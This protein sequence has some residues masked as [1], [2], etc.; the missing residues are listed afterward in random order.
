MAKSRAPQ[1]NHDARIGAGLLTDS[2]LFNRFGYGITVSQLITDSGRTGSL[3]RS[4]KLQSEASKQDALAA[5]DDVLLNVQQ[6]YYGVQLAQALVELAGQTVKTRQT[7]VDQISE[8]AKNKLKSNL[9]VN[10]AQVNLTD[11]QLMLLRARSNLDSAFAALNEALGSR[12]AIR[13]QLAPVDLPAA[14]VTTAEPLVNDAFA[15]RPELASL[16]LQTQSGEA[17]QRAERDLK[18]PTVTFNG[19]AG[20]LPFIVPGNAN[21]NIPAEYEGAEINVQIPVFNGHLFSAR[22]RAAGYQVAETQQRFRQLEDQIARDVR[23]AWA[24][25]NTA[26][27]AIGASQQLVQQANGALDLA[28]GRYN[29]GL[30]SIVELTQAQLGQTQAQVQNLNAQYEYQQAYS[31][32]Q[33]AEG[34]LH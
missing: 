11:A 30:S 31:A 16:R 26:Y 15:H 2:R 1:A 32:L 12:D 27:Q 9:D 33:Y 25:A 29:L 3:V 34:L 23:T 18:R 22:S 6:A 20:F 17:F 5:R 28:Q 14:P 21:P 7:V 13:Y 24:R 10:F 19:V 8:L 4:A